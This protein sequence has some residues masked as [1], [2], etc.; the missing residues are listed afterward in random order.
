MRKLKMTI[1][2]VIL[3]AELLDTPTAEAMLAA[4]PFESRIATWGDEVYF[5]APIQAD[6][7]AAARDVVEAGEIAYRP[8]GGAVIV[9][10][11]PT[12][13]SEGEEIRLATPSNVFARTEGDVHALRTVEPGQLVTIELVD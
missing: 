5:P 1:G 12:P 6:R 7:E 4:V 8:E 10:F 9:G 3:H 2:R 11:G 13:M